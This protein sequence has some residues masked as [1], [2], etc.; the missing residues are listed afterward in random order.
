MVCLENDFIKAWIKPKGAELKSLVCKASG[1]E[2]VWD[3][4]PRY[5]GKSSPVLFPIVGG[6]KDNSYTYDGESYE[7]S[8]HGFARDMVFEVESKNSETATFLL[9]STEETLKVYPFSF[10]L[11]LIYT[12]LENQLELKYEVKSTGN[13]TMYFSIGGHPAFMVPFGEEG[14]YSEYKLELPEDTSLKRWLLNEQGLL[15]GETE[16]VELTNGNLPLSKELFYK[17]ALV[18]KDLES[19]SITLS[20][21]QSSNKLVFSFE[22]FPFFGI[23]AAK[24]AP[25]VCL[26]PWCGVA[27]SAE[28]NQELTQKEGIEALNSGQVFTRAWRVAVS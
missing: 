21:A 1:I 12:I 23:W 8:R 24:D 20:S 3:A 16:E 6:L 26:E 9:K 28:H 2:H 11:R 10:E 4:N 5:W 19:K 14:S 13:N 27:D 22:D 17:D 7:L 25:F 15:N 18:L